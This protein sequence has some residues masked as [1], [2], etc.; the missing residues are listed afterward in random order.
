VEALLAWLV[1]RLGPH[2]IARTATIM[3]WVVGTLAALFFLLLIAA[4]L[5]QQFGV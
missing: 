3:A 4:V 2:A 5:W 1:E